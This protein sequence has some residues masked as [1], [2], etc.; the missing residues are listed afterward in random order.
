[1][2]LLYEELLEWSVSALYEATIAMECVGSMKN[3]WKGVCRLYEVLLEMECICSMR[4]YWCVVCLHYE[5]IL[6]CSVSAL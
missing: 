3:C 6:E 1:M 2:C 5:V 4:Y